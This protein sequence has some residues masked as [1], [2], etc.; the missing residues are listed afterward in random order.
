MDWLR[1][2]KDTTPPPPEPPPDFSGMD[3]CQVEIVIEDLLGAVV[4]RRWLD[5]WWD[6]EIVDG[7]TPRQMLEGRR[8]RQLWLIAYATAS[9]DDRDITDLGQVRC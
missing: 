5:Q 6:M 1:E 7:Q 8:F 3:A 4:E 9:D 2:G